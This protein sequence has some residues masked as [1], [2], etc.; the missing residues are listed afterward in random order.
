MPAQQR[1][2]RLSDAF[3]RL[4]A[5]RFRKPLPQPTPEPADPNT[6]PD[7][8]PNAN[9]IPVPYLDAESP[10]SSSAI[11]SLLTR[12]RR[13]L[14]MSAAGVAAVGVLLALPPIRTELRNSFTR[15][16]QPYTA[17]YF[18][19]PPRVDSTVLTVPVSVHAVDT[20]TDAYSV[21]VWTVDAKGRVDDSQS[22]DL[23]WDGQA[24]SAVVS[25]PVNPQ[26]DYVWV[27]LTGSD[28]T[29]HYK[30]AVA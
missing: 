26:A 2:G 12:Q 30:I 11:R 19:S 13:R 22:A 23:K 21:R 27:S 17:L 18:T 1:Q 3:A 8:G 9:T 14:T 24:L 25:M 6:G 20:S 5:A 28:E 10:R 7:T 29:L 16:P 4:F 15:L